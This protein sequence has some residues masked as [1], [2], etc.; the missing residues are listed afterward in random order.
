MIRYRKGPL[1]T[2]VLLVAFCAQLFAQKGEISTEDA[3]KVDKAWKLFLDGMV[4][5]D[6]VLLRGL[7]LGRVECMSCMERR[8][9]ALEYHVGLD[10]FLR[11]MYGDWTPGMWHAIR[12]KKY[13]ANPIVTTNTPVNVVSTKKHFLVY[14]LIFTTLE[15][16]EVAPGHEGRQHLFQFIDIDGTLK[17]Y[18]LTTVP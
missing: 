11:H 5:R 15:R 13:W 7:S 6:T 8:P 9:D 1:V 18:G 16:N 14:E 3:L 4:R 17:F 2:I 10:T 12:T